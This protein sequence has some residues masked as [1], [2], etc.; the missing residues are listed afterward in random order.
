MKLKLCTVGL[1]EFYTKANPLFKYLM[2]YDFVDEFI[3]GFATVILNNKYNFIDGDGNLL[4]QQWFDMTGDFLE[5]FAV[6]ELYGKYNFINTGG[7]IAFRQW[8]D[9]ATSF[10]DGF[11][12]VRLNGTYYKLDPEAV[13]TRCA[14]RRPPRSRS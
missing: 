14:A 10:F 5:G 8:F 12:E 4:S 3:N 1:A 11:A 6:V 2:K 7:E 13:C 9:M